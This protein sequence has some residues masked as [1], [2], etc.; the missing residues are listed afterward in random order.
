MEEKVPCVNCG[1]PL[2][3]SRYGQRHND[4]YICISCLQ[5]EKQRLGKVVERLSEV[6]GQMCDQLASDLEERIQTGRVAK[7]L[8]DS[9]AEGGDLPFW[10]IG[11]EVI[12]SF[13]MGYWARPG[14]PTTI[15]EGTRGRITS[16]L[17]DGRIG[18]E[19]E[20]HIGLHTFAEPARLLTRLFS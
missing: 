13:P 11:A 12:A 8:L 10:P 6:L 19:F 7:Q 14:T 20:G 18:V 4:P 1:L 2:P 3:G 17:D 15:E 5:G 16:Y 9:L